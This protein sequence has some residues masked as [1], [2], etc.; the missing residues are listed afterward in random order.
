MT[1][2][3]PEWLPLDEDAEIA[4]PAAPPEPTLQN[5]R[6]RGGHAAWI[7]SA[8]VIIAGYIAGYI[9][10][11]FGFAWSLPIQDVN[12][13]AGVIAAAIGFAVSRAKS[14]LI[15]RRR[16]RHHVRQQPWQP[17][18][19]YAQDPQYQGTVATQARMPERRP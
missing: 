15:N 16:I 11:T 3:A 17:H 1:D 6:N 19:A 9:E 18:P 5:A 14:A 2:P 10:E 7:S 4:G 12:A 8:S 13:L